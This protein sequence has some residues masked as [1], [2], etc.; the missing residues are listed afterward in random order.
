MKETPPHH[1]FL[2]PVPPVQ[3]SWER[4]VPGLRRR[5][6]TLDSNP[7]SIPDSSGLDQAE[8]FSGSIK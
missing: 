5:D 4:L 6:P 3:E 1:S 2:R 8:P 7:D